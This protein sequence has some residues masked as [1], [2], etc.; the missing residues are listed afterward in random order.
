MIASPTPVGYH[1][2]TVYQVVKDADQLLKFVVSAFDGTETERI[3]RPDG[4]VGHA[5]VK[6]GDSVLMVSEASN[7]WP[8]MPAAIYLY[9]ADCDASYERAIK[10]GGTS[11]SSPA[12][13]FYGDRSAAI[14][15]PV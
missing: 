10:A 11:V 5:E 6:I 15:G 13:Q 3:M 12:T 7:E 9:V 1:T 14:R 4:T 8:P 2:V